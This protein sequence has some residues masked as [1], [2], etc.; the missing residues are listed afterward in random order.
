[1][2]HTLL[3]ATLAAIM[4]EL[5]RGPRT[6]AFSGTAIAMPVGRELWL[7]SFNADRVAYRPLGR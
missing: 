2:S 5:A 3:T 6:T 4:T 1:M 7:G